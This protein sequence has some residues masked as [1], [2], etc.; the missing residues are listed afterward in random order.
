MQYGHCVVSATATAISS[1]YLSGIAPSLKAA[2]SNVLS[3]YQRRADLVPNLVNVVK[4]A[5]GQE[6]Q[7]LDDVVQARSRVGSI[8]S[9]PREE[10]AAG[11]TG[12]A[13]ALE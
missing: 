2:W 6:R 9:I 4:G 12:E 5:A 8:Q 3:Q 7:V 1:L 10:F 13:I 11:F